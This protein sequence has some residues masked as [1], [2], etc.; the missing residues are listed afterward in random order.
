MLLFYIQSE[1]SYRDQNTEKDNKEMD[2]A[3]QCYISY[4]SILCQAPP[5]GQVCAVLQTWHKAHCASTDAHPSGG[6]ACVAVRGQHPL[7][8]VGTQ[9]GGGG[10]RNRAGKGVSGQGKSLLLVVWCALSIVRK[11]RIYLDNLSAVS[12]Y[13]CIA[14][15]KRLETMDRKETHGLLWSN[16]HSACIG[17]H[18]LLNYGLAGSRRCAQCLSR[19]WTLSSTKFLV[20]V[21]SVFSECAEFECCSLIGNVCEHLCGGLCLQNWCRVMLII[22]MFIEAFE[23]CHDLLPFCGWWWFMLF[24]KS[25]YSKQIS[26][27]ARAVCSKQDFL[28]FRNLSFCFLWIDS[29]PT[30]W[31]WNNML[32]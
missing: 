10:G 25:G 22:E 18:E 15:W 14:R 1:I 4:S 11:L 31:K 28:Y 19:S 6:K 8:Q 30:I 24:Q 12:V 2:Q 29:S 21:L 23:G 9:Q 13:Q 26:S 5:A 32:K 27:K 7:G 3:A 17:Q 16:G 20:Y